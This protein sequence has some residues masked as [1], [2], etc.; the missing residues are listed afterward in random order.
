MKNKCLPTFC[1]LRFFHAF[2]SPLPLDLY[3]DDKPFAKNILYEDF[4][5]YK[6]LLAQDYTLTL[7]KHHEKEVLFTQTFHLH[8]KKNYTIALFP[9]ADQCY[10]LLLLNEP[11][12]E[13]PDEMLLA[14]TINLTSQTDSLKL[15]FKEMRPE[16]KKLQ[17]AHFTSYLAYKDGTYHLQLLQ[18]STEKIV[19]EQKEINLK[20]SRY[21]A[22]YIIGG[23]DAYPLKVIS[24]IEGSSLY[25]FETT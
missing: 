4:T 1:N 8:M 10:Q 2:P 20:A 3:I 18:P 7:C 14:R 11:S 6:P 22:F 16:F 23:L 12:K 17:A 9:T 19:Y 25:H 24:H 21:Y 13:I 5:T 15:L